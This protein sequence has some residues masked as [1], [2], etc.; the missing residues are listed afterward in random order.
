MDRNAWVNKSKWIPGRYEVSPQG[1]ALSPL[2]G[3]RAGGWNSFSIAMRFGHAWVTECDGKQ[4]KSLFWGTR[5]L[6]ADIPARFI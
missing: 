6:P 2:T 4:P 1:A 5:S 3:Y